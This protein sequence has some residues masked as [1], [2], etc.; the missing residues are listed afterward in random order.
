MKS[1]KWL[2]LTLLLLLVLGAAFACGPKEPEGITA[3]TSIFAD[4]K[5]EGVD[6]SG[7]VLRISVCVDQNMGNS[8]P[9][10]DRI[11]ADLILRRATRSSTR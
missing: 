9:T 10:S 6:F 7:T 8:T 2:A 11:S 4:T 1:F 5:W 3:D